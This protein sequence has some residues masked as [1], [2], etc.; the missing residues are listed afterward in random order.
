MSRLEERGLLIV[1][2][3]RFPLM[4]LVSPVTS[5]SGAMVLCVVVAGYPPSGLLRSSILETDNR[6]S[7]SG[8]F[9]CQRRYSTSAR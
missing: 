8:H 6:F 3:E 5:V 4:G 9:L 1:F 2:R 7:N